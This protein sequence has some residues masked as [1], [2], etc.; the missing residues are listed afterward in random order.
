MDKNIEEL[1]LLLMYLTS[2]N[3]KGYVYNESTNMPEEA[4]IKNCWKGYNFD[5]LNQL[6]EKGY[7]YPGKHENKSVTMTKD[8]EKLA[9]ELIHKYLK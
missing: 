2:W 9:E 1:T 4:T 7:L 6:T 3:E 8:G 5:I